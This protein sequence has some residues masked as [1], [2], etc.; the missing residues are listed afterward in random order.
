MAS[1]RRI[2]QPGKRVHPLLGLFRH[3]VASEAADDL[4]RNAEHV[5]TSIGAA[6]VPMKHERTIYI[7]PPLS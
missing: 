4:L 5:I 3:W 7:K 6:F 2:G 1:G